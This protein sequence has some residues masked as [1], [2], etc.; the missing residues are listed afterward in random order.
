[1]QV[2]EAIGR[3][4]QFFFYAVGEGVGLVLFYDVFRILRRI[5]RHGNVWVGLEDIVY[6]VLCTIAVFL[7]LHEKN[8]GMVRAFAFMG[9][10]IGIVIYYLLFSRYV[11][12]LCV[13]L[14][15]GLIHQI[16]RILHYILGPFIKNGRK[17]WIFLKKQLKK[18][19]RAI[20]IGLCKL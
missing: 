5:V 12:K 16:G 4:A 1:M 9:I 2:S 18:L 3:E 15:G 8:D 17:I 10:S 19:Y 20:K 6:W 11:I 14:F 7:L 13:F